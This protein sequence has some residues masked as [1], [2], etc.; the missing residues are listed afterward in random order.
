MFAYHSGPSLTR[1]LG[2]RGAVRPGTTSQ[3][4][5]ARAFRA[6]ADPGLAAVTF[7]PGIKFMPAP[8]EDPA[9]PG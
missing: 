6:G 8:F 5:A 9:I 2:K 1:L 3:R 7:A 4:A